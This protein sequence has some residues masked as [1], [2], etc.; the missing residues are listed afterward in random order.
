MFGAEAPAQSYCNIVDRRAQGLGVGDECIGVFVHWLG[1]VEMYV[2]V[3]HVT[4]SNHPY[5]VNV[6]LGVSSGLVDK[7][8]DL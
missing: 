7:V 2:A 4:E 3:A 6:S 1:Q 8:G 5:I